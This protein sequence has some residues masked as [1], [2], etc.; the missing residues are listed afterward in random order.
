MR[1]SS[2][3]ELCSLPN[4]FRLVLQPKAN[5]KKELEEKQGERITLGNNGAFEADLDHA[6]VSAPLA[7][8][9]RQNRAERIAPHTQINRS[10]SPHLHADQELF[11]PSALVHR[12][13]RRPA[14]ISDRM[15][16]TSRNRITLLVADATRNRERRTRRTHLRG[17]GSYSV[18]VLICG[19]TGIDVGHT[20][21]HREPTVGG[22]AG[23]V[24]ECGESRADHVLFPRHWKGSIREA[25]E[26]TPKY[27]CGSRAACKP[28]CSTE[29]PTSS[30]RLLLRAAETDLR[31][32]SR[33]V[34]VVGA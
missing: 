8:G 34:V 20:R 15:A 28:T 22:L 17:P 3:A 16:N 21:T 14:R 25:S 9:G 30:T 5:Q 2:R 29:A 11:E 13:R 19:I 4:F 31:G 24:V 27:S 10:T 1:D 23:H 33:Q 18:A 26:G 12:L 7:A 6:G 32:A